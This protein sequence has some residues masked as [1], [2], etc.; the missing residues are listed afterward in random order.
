LGIFRENP[1]A[2]C[3]RQLEIFGGSETRN[4]LAELLTSQSAREDLRARQ[5]EYLSMLERLRTGE[6]ALVSMLD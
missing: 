2:R 4:G 6:E 3:M 1:M 5:Q